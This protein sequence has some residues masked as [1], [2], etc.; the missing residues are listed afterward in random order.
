[1]P[2]KRRKGQTVVSLWLSPDERETLSA[3]A[4]SLGMTYSDFIRYAMREIAA[5]R[6]LTQPKPE[7]KNG[8]NK[9]R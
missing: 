6:G 9:T 8:H 3:A 4:S 7:D 5:R 2:N 1:M